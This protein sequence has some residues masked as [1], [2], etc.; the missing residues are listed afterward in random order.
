MD[1]LLPPGLLS[2][3]R[4]SQNVLPALQSPVQAQRNYGRRSPV[5]AAPVAFAPLAVARVPAARAA[6]EQHAEGQGRALSSAPGLHSRDTEA[7]EK[8]PAQ[9]RSGR[10]ERVGGSG[11]FGSPRGLGKVDKVGAEGCSGLS[12][13]SGLGSCERWPVCVL[14]GRGA[15]RERAQRRVRARTGVPA[16]G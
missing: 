8:N 14:Q 5:P 2:H 3:P 15:A 16:A 13:G 12:R 9:K 7:P 11:I 6:R 10:E 4:A 1:L